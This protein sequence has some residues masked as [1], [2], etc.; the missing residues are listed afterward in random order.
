MIAKPTTIFNSFFSR[1]ILTGFVLVA[2]LASANDNWCRHIGLVTEK[3]QEFHLLEK[4]KNAELSE[5]VFTNFFDIVDAQHVFLSEEDIAKFDK[6]RHVLFQGNSSCE[7]IEVFSEFFI[8]RLGEFKQKLQAIQQDKSFF[9]KKRTINYHQ[10]LAH[11]SINLEGLESAWSDYVALFSMLELYKQ[12]DKD[13][14]YFVNFEVA[15]LAKSK[16]KVIDR[17]VCRLSKF[18]TDQAMLKDMSTTFI[19]AFSRSF[20]PHTTYFTAETYNLFMASLSSEEASYGIELKINEAGEVLISGVLPGSAAWRS[21]KV[22]ENDVIKAL[23]YNDKSVDLYCTSVRQIMSQLAEDKPK[24]ILLEIQ[25]AN[26]ERLTIDL[27]IET[28]VNQE[29]VVKGFVLDDDENK[30]GYI[31]IPTFYSG[32]TNYPGGS[33][34][35]DAAKEIMKLNRSGISGLILDMRFNSGGSMLEAVNL[36]GSFIDIGPVGMLSS[37]GESTEI[38]KDLNRGM[39]YSGPVVV[40]VNGMS[41]SATEFLAAALQDYNRAVIVGERT[42]GKGSVQHL[43]PIIDYRSGNY[44]DP[45]GYIKVTTNLIYRVTNKSHQGVGVIPDIELNGVFD[46]ESTYENDEPNYIK[47]DSIDK[48]VRFQKRS[49]LPISELEARSQQRIAKSNFLNELSDFIENNQ[50]LKEKD[51]LIR[52]GI[53]NLEESYLEFKHNLWGN[54]KIPQFS[55]MHFKANNHAYDSDLHQ[56]DTFLKELDDEVKKDIES[57]W[58]IHESFM[59]LK[60]LIELSKQ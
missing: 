21:N 54:D 8:S 5:Q 47:A 49:S 6:Y 30:I 39:A 23:S 11:R 19:Q 60:D 20:D 28:V 25:K 24:F 3:I 7:F 34:A 17:L 59:I 56:Y 53:E 10:F 32:F 48:Q 41:A 44:I 37:R 33:V 4:S 9:D 45:I 26:Q 50:P 35:N 36:S 58:Q 42:Y 29:N 13:S 1:C 15:K 38:L 16:Q 27:P 22:H 51:F 57:D 40:L 12:R 55:Q 46:F 18:E 14:V 2:H 31:N 52:I 43:V